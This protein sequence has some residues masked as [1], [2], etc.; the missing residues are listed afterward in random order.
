[1]HEKEKFSAKQTLLERVSPTVDP[2]LVL[3]VPVHYLLAEAGN[4]AREAVQ[5]NALIRNLIFVFKIDDDQADVPIP[6][7]QCCGSVSF[8]YR[9]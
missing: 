2:V 6:N 5:A 1:M 7:K 4:R 9:S 8:L 3:D